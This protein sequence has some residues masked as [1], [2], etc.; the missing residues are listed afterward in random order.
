MA[1]STTVRMPNP[2]GVPIRGKYIF[3]GTFALKIVKDVIIRAIIKGTIMELE[4]TQI[5]NRDIANITF[6][7]GLTW[8]NSLLWAILSTI[9]FNI[10]SP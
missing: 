3:K 7:F 8:R 6:N 10:N 2:T 5:N 1:I 4:K 9:F